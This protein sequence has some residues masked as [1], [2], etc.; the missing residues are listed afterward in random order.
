MIKVK[1]F[2]LI[3]IAINLSGCTLI[4]DKKKIQ[5]LVKI[6][7]QKLKSKNKVGTITFVRCDFKEQK[8]SCQKEKSRYTIYETQNH[9]VI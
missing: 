2:V 5:N 6:V 1:I 9:C 4:D 7:Q 8:F 3:A